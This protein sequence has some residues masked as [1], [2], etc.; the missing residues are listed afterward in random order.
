MALE[1]VII[2]AYFAILTT[3]F[4]KKLRSFKVAHEYAVAFTFPLLI[5]LLALLSVISSSSGSNKYLLGS[6]FVLIVYSLL[7]CYTML[8]NLL[9]MVRLWQDIG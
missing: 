6:T 9:D 5:F 1:G 8:K 3:E 7:N 4:G 2:A